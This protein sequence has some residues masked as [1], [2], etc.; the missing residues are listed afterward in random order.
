MLAKDVSFEQ[1]GLG[2][3]NTIA[4][5]Q[6][7][8]PLSSTTEHPSPTLAVVVVFSQQSLQGQG[9]GCWSEHGVLGTPASERDDL[10][11]TS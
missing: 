9:H 7:F 1:P 5:L 10:K 11:L 8:S 6:G 4:Y 3:K 2:I